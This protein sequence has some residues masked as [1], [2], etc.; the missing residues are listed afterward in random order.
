MCVC[1]QFLYF[2]KTEMALEKN[3]LKKSS[4]SSNSFRANIMYH[5][6]NK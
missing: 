2:N 6:P 4:V 1:N 5:D 3:K